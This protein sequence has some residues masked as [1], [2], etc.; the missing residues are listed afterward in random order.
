[1]NNILESHLPQIKDL[2]QQHHVKALFAFG[3]V[4]TGK[5][6]KSSDIDLLISFHPMEYGEYAD[7]YFEIADK[8]EAVFKRP[9]DLLSEKS[10]KNPYF[11][12]SVNNSK[13]LLY[14]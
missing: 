14:G 9:V 12:K 10:L 8:L 2:C 7:N 3:S 4:V 13:K 6:S 11:I 1:M 5:F